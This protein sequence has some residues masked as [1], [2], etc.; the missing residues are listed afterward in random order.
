MMS[1]KG[2]IYKFV[3]FKD[4]RSETPPLEFVPVM[5]EFAKVVTNDFI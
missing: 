4:L 3:R 5:K 2:C 1:S